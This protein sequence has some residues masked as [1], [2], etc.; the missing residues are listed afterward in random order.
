MNIEVKMDL[1]ERNIIL[2][3]K[4]TPICINLI[5]MTITLSYFY[6]YN[7][8]ILELY[9]KHIIYISVIILLISFFFSFIVSNYIEKILLDYKNKLLQNIE[10]NKKRDLYIFQESKALT[11]SELMKNISHQWRQ[12]LSVISTISS[13]M[14]LKKEM[15]INN[16]KEEIEFLEIININTKQL[17]SI[18][19]NLTNS[20][21]TNKEKTIFSVNQM[22]D[23]CIEIVYEQFDSYNIKFEK[24]I[25]EFELN[26]NKNQLIQAILNFL[27]NSRDKFLETN[28]DNKIIK[29]E[30]HENPVYYYI[31]ITD[32][33]GGIEEEKLNKIFD[34]FFTTKH[35]SNGN[36]TGI[37]LY[38]SNQI[39]SKMFNGSILVKNTK[40]P[41]INTLYDGLIFKIMI[42]KEKNNIKI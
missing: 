35:Q 10:K 26:G 15:N 29:I 37:G 28:I 9:Y 24:N 4:Y 31:C 7:V 42:S 21:S 33:A 14:K 8:N 2:I 38:I 13:G 20:Y 41:Y 27:N 12:H 40:I 18:L 1:K 36:G 22:I 25:K 11:I 5:I 30:T 3:I 17:S 16:V 32:N 23:E 19:D 6:L 34:P 39:I